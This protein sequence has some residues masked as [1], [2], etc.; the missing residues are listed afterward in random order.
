MTLI[1]REDSETL[2]QKSSKDANMSF[3]TFNKAKED[4]HYDRDIALYHLQQA[5]EKCLKALLI[6]EDVNY[7]KS[8]DINY[9]LRCVT[10][11]LPNTESIIKY[12]DEINMW[13]AATRYSFYELEDENIFY[14]VAMDYCTLYRFVNSL[15]SN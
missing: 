9:L 1:S 2:L 6:I 14:A 10:H 8:H 7:K 11:Q 3:I 5:I 12:A 13:E 15:L 4:W